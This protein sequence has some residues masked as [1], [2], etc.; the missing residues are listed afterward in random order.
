MASETIVNENVIIKRIFLV[1]CCIILPLA[2]FIVVYLFTDKPKPI[3]GCI[4]NKRIATIAS[5]SSIFDVFTNNSKYYLTINGK[6]LKV[7]DK[8]YKMLAVGDYIFAAYRNE[9]LYHYSR[10]PI[11]DSWKMGVFK[12]S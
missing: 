12:G 11:K 2:P 4:T 8:I 5:S 1:F 3:E 10:V 6:D 7:S 9:T